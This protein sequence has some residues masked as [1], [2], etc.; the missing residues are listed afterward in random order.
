MDIRESQMERVGLM[1]LKSLFRKTFRTSTVLITGHTGFKGGWLSLWLESLGA[2]IV[3]YSLD[4]PGTPSFF[5]V[6]RLSDHITDIRGDIRDYD[7]L[8]E[9]IGKYRPD[10][11]FHLAAQPIVRESYHQPLETFS[12]NVMGTA[13]L[14]ESIR[15]IPED[16]VCVCITSDKCYENREW[17]HAYRETDPLGGYDPYS[18]SKAAAEIVIASYRSSFFNGSESGSQVR[19]VA[20]ARAG[21]IIGGGDWAQDRIV[22]DCIRSLAE[23]KDILLR[24]PAAVRPWQFVLEPLAGYLLLAC[25]MREDPSSYSDAWNFGPWHTST[26]DVRSLAGM[27]A[28]AWGGGKCRIAPGMKMQPHE[29]NCLK[30]DIAKSVAGLGWRPV[31]SIDEA[32]SQT[33]DW[34]RHYYAGDSDMYR[35]SRDQIAGYIK[36][37]AEM[38]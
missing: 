31:Y 17:S 8:S 32:V 20:S 16:T 13:V 22:P 9:T 33:V 23:G 34:Y 36:K 6:A 7:K 27:I 14:L 2:D 11:I 37:S 24:N 19:P 25:K 4:P 18:A 1:Q 29:A 28:R 3:G 38:S 10:F 26:V 12:V 35:F 21:N 5:E 30:L 15:K